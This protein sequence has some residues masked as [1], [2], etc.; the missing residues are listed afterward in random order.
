VDRV[1]AISDTVNAGI[2]S[3]VL[4]EKNGGAIVARQAAERLGVSPTYLAKILQKLAAKGLLVPRRGLGG[5]YA[6]ARSS[7]EISCLDILSALEGGVPTRECLFAKAVCRS[8][9]CALR[10]CCEEMEERLR[11]VLAATTISAVA[12]SF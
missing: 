6:L 7:E 4:A 2:H 5:G 8:K 9:S 3:L 11:L 12:R 10:A 1:I